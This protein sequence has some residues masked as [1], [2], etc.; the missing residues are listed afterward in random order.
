MVKYKIWCQIS[1]SGW[2]ILYDSYKI[3]CERVYILPYFRKL[4]FYLIFVFLYDYHNKLLKIAS[5]KPDNNTRN[6]RQVFI[7][8]NLKFDP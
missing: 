6:L 1:T 2:V 3:S 4:I 7:T 5:L 8:S